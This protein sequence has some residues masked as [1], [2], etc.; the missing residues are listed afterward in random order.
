MSKIIWIDQ[1]VY[2]EENK[3]YIKILNGLGYKKL[4]LYQ[5]VCDA[6][7]DMKT[8][9]FE[10]TKIMVSGRLF[11]DLINMLKANIKDICFAPKIIVFTIDKNDFLKYNKEDYESIEN[12]FY[13][14][15]GIATNIDEIKIFLK[16][17]NA[18]INQKDSSKKTMSSI[19]SNEPN[20]TKNK[21]DAPLTFE[22]ID[23]KEK[24]FLPIFFK[25]L[26]DSVS[27]ENMDEYTKSLYNIFSKENKEIKELLE[28]ILIMKNIPIEILCKYYARLYT[29]E[30]S[31]YD[32]LN[33]DLRMKNKDKYLPYIKTFYEGVKL[34]SLPLASNNILYRGGHL[35]KDEINIIQKYLKNKI[36]DLPG[37]IV[38]SKSFLSFSKDEKEA[39]KFYK[40]QN[41]P[42]VLFKLINENKEGYNLATHG[43]IEKISYFPKEKEVLFFPFSSFEIKD[44]KETK[45]ESEKGYEIKLLYLGKYLKDIENNNNLII[46]ENKIPDSEFKKQLSELGLIK[47]EKIQNINKKIKA[48]FSIDFWD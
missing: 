6:I 43:D 3:G 19:N 8:I 28:Q 10:E 18:Q 40:M 27:N 20:A 44:I 17:G 42:K 30:S 12:K 32:N 11:K 4:K 41:S 13:T 36:K 39:I 29:G 21:Y 37:S 26:I 33:N 9:L 47:E 48:F 15:G 46:N 25:S 45:I 31:F 14:F 2:N 16:R 22:Y 5:K 1:E 35:S 24:L 38:F 7:A 34:K 23:S